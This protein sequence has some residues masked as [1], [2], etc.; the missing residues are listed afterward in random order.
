LERGAL[1]RII[2]KWSR[3][4]MWFFRAAG[5]VTLMRH[6]CGVPFRPER[7]CAESQPQQREP[8]AIQV[9]SENAL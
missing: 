6:K 2:V 9:L 8:T 4:V 7:G 1:A 3:E 5:G